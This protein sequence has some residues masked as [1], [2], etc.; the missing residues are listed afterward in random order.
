[1]ID[2]RGIVSIFF[3]FFSLSNLL[4]RIYLIWTHHNTDILNTDECIFFRCICD[5]CLIYVADRFG[6]RLDRVL[7]SLQRVVNKRSVYFLINTRQPRWNWRKLWHSTN[8]IHTYYGKWQMPGSCFYTHCSSTFFWCFQTLWRLS[9]F[10]GQSS[11]KWKFLSDEDVTMCT[12]CP[13]R[14]EF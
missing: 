12:Q 10:V 14:P 6:N 2:L 1:M 5:I 3:F 9:G 4:L 7:T 8:A 13:H 11:Y